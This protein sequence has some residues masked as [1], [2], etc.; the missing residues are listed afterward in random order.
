MKRV[1][2]ILLT[3]YIGAIV[4]GMLIA[5]A[6]MT[7]ISIVIQPIIWYSTRASGSALGGSAP[8]FDFSRSLSPGL[9]TVLYVA[10]SYVLLSWLYGSGPDSAD[11]PENQPEAQE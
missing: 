8:G 3:Q 9:T 7:A 4:V 6:V 11:T 10:V 5:Q 2:E 1:R